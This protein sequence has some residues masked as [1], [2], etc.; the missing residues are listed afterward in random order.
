MIE[1]F[2]DI[3]DL[4]DPRLP[5]RRTSSCDPKP[6]LIASY[7]ALNPDG[8]SL[9]SSALGKKSRSAT[10]N[11]SSDVGKALLSFKR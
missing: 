5:P 8:Y 3:I 11:N 9:K 10:S 6:P 4:P 7:S 2:S 1:Q